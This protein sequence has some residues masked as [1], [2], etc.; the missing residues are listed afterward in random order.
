MKI[1]TRTILFGYHQFIIHPIIV[2]VAWWREYGVPYDPR[3][4][5]AF[6]VHDFGYWGKPNLDGPEGEEHPIWG[7]AL[8]TKWF[9]K[10]WGDLCLYHSR[11]YALKNNAP[12]SRL[13]VADKIAYLMYPTWLILFLNTLSGEQK[14]YDA[15]AARRKLAYG[16]RNVI[17]MWK[18]DSQRWLEAYHNGTDKA[19]IEALKNADN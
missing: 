7:A 5:V 17:E 13:C 9:G 19:H 11:F 18:V 12:V 8:M 1:G 4:W 6:F 16:S 14:E 3:L 2:A 10:E 15:I